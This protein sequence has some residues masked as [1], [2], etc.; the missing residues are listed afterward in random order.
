VAEKL[1]SLFPGVSDAIL[2]V[3]TKL[4]ETAGAFMSG[5]KSEGK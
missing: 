2:S 3:G 4:M 5:G 1:A